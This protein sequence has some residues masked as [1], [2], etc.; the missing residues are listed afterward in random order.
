ME[1]GCN[2]TLNRIKTWRKLRKMESEN[3]WDQNW[4]DN[5]YDKRVNKEL[6]NHIVDLCKDKQHPKILELGAGSGNDSICLAKEGYD[7]TCIDESIE[8][9]KLILKK[10]KE[11]NVKI[12]VIHGD[13]TAITTTIQY[14]IVFSQGVIEHQRNYDY[15]IQNHYWFVKPEGHLLISV[16]HFW[17]PY[18]M[19]KEVLQLFRKWPHGYERSLTKHDMKMIGKSINS[20][21]VDCF[22][23][24]YFPNWNWLKPFM[25]WFKVDICG[26]YQI[27]K[28]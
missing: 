7:V 21:M 4:K 3:S 9:C 17:S 11:L 22:F 1:R 18:M 2:E 12:V 16:P 10:A 25:E 13:F 8:S 19:Y 28:S 23:Y 5:A 27:I 6:V 20:P 24:G 14:D 15:L 26:V